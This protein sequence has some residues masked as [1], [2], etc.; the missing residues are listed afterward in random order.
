MIA[1]LP[2]DQ[3]IANSAKAIRARDFIYLAS[4]ADTLNRYTDIM[5]RKDNVNRLRWGALDLLIVRGGSLTPTKMARLTFRSKHSIT[6]VIDSLEKDGFLIR[7]H[8]DQ[9]RRKIYIKVTLAGLEY[10]M[11]SLRRSDGVWNPLTSRL[12]RDERKLLL[13]L[14]ERLRRMMIDEITRDRQ[15]KKE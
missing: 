9:D 15:H 1:K 14:T 12:N 6:K 13:N 5:L 10:V 11:Q 7:Q 8:S 4:F 3:Q 2:N